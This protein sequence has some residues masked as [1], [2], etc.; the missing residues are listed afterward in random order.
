MDNVQKE[1]HVVSVLGQ[2]LAT[3]A[4]LREQKDDRYLPHQI[5]RPRLTAREEKSSNTSGNREEGSSDKEE[6]HPCRFK[7]C[8]HPVM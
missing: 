4:R 5:R 8:E 6:R 3:D 7:K 1:T 2:R